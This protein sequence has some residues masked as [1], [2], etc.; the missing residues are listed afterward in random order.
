MNG[1]RHNTWYQD[2]TRW[3]FFFRESAK[4]SLLASSDI[5]NTEATL[6]LQLD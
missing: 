3:T 6:L 2:A 4:G 5:L 1:K